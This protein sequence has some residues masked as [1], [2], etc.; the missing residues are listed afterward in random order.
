[1][2]R[3]LVSL[4]TN[5]QQWLYRLNKPRP[6]SP[7]RIVCIADTH[8]REYP[9]PPGNVLIHAGDLT[10]SGTLAELQDAIAWL[11]AQPHA[12]KIAIAGNADLALDP[13]LRSPSSADVEW[14]DVTYLC[15]SAA[16]IK[17]AAGRE[18]TIY[19]DPHVPRCGADGQEA[20]QYEIDDDYWHD[21]IPSRA[22]VVVTH[23]PPRHILDEWDGSP[24]GCASLYNEVERVRPALHVFGHVH[25]AYGREDVLW[26]NML[27]EGHFLR[28]MLNQMQDSSVDAL[29]RLL[30]RALAAPVMSVLQLFKSLIFGGNNTVQ[31]TV[32]VNAAAMA[33]DGTNL[34]NTP[35]VV[36]M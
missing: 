27:Y 12:H 20:F 17:L 13:K 25:P 15:K 23:T 14:G 3:Q 11:N 1:M 4:V 21:T 2:L 28:R 32:F 16:T 29:H 22:D 24:D 33:A 34:K 5:T 30:L 31:R 6:G 26:E 18:L 35:V 36:D 9:I 7:V 19:G 10:K 8:S